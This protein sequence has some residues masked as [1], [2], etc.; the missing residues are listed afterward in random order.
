MNPNKKIRIIKREDKGSRSKVAETAA[1]SRE[2]LRQTTR[3]V[4]GQV[5]AWVREAQQR[6]PADPRRAFA[7][8]FVKQALPSN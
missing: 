1:S 4:T 2:N 7:S 3:E 6:R 5:T 8:L